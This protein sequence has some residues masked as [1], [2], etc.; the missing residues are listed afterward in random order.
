MA[1][2]SGPTLGDAIADAGNELTK[3]VVS[4]SDDVKLIDDLF[5]RILNRPATQQEIATCRNDMRAVDADHQR[6]AEALGK[7][8]TAYALK[9]PQ[10][11]RERQAAIAAAQA[12]LAAYEKEQAPVLAEQARKKAESTAK[13]EAELAAYETTLIAKKTA[14]WEKEKA[15]SIINRW[16]VVEP[17]TTA[18]TNGSTATKEPDGSIIVTGRNRNGIVTITAET[19]LTGIVGLRLEVLTDSRL[20]Q[21]GPGRAADGNFVLNEFELAAA[22]KADPKQAKPVKLANPMA[23]FSQDNLGIAQAI[24]GSFNDPGNGWAIYPATGAIHWATFETTEPLGAPGGTILTF[25]LHHKYNNAWTLG[26][27]RLSVTRGA[28]PIGLSLPEDF[29]SV[30]ATVSDVRTEAQKTLLATYHRAVDLELRKKI[31]AVS[32]SKLPSPLDPRL[33]ALRD[34][35]QFVQQPLQPEPALVRLRHDLEMS[36]QQAALRRLTATQDISWALINSPAFLFNH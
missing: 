20:P 25:K 34:Q 28:K 19:D 5:M 27:F 3:L 32:A 8:E 31:E 10:L 21:K 16:L 2:V 17:R 23:D 18:T 7:A 6:L 36:V 1:L 15:A 30:L 24:D 14:D 11:E 29:R 26:R 4:Q 22:P 35:L 33:K 12:A 13:L 9:R